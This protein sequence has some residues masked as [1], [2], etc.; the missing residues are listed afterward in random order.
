MN[1]LSAKRK[2]SILKI[3][4]FFVCFLNIF[5]ITALFTWIGCGELWENIDNE[6]IVSF[7]QWV[8]IVIYRILI[9]LLPALILSIFRFDKRY[10]WM[11][12]FIMI[13]SWT[14]FIYLFCNVII[15]FFEIDALLKI[16]IFENIDVAVSLLGYVMTAFNKRKIEF[17]STGAI[18]GELKQ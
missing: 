7:T 11:S 5:I 1:K 15:K 10:N 3:S 9:Y 16:K 12:R 8:S 4:T 13:L 14:F 2:L 18:I 17:D 6:G